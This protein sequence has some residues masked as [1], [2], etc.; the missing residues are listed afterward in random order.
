VGV[1]REPCLGYQDSFGWEDG[2]M[3]QGTLGLNHLDLVYPT[4]RLWSQ[5]YTPN[6]SLAD[7]WLAPLPLLQCLSFPALISC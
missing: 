7:F 1:G 3:W 5:S 4:E 6:S 2:E